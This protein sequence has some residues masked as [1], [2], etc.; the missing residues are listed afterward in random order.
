MIIV[1]KTIMGVSIFR[2]DLWYFLNKD[3]SKAK[4]LM[5]YRIK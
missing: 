1:A 4:I 3:S 2:G 5:D